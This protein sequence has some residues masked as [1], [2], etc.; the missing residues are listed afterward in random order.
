MSLQPHTLLF[1]LVGEKNDYQ[2][3]IINYELRYIDV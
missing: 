2:L 3:R 1:I